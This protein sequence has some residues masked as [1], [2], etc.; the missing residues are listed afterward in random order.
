[1]ARVADLHMKWMKE[2]KYRK[3]Y[4]ALEEEFVLASAVID[5][6]NRAGLTQ[7]ALA[8]KM[9]NDS[10]RR[11][12]AGKRA[13]TSVAAH[14]RKARPRNQVASADSLRAS[15]RNETPYASCQM[16]HA[17]NW[18]RWRPCRTAGSGTGG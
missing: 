18:R 17:R 11:C 5:A 2:P 13:R 12:P 9:G 14:P 8:K 6:R 15:T 4:E 16:K 3:A 1:M 7:Q 10:A